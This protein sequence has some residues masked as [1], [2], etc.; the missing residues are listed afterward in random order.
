MGTTRG[1]IENRP[2][3]L[4]RALTKIDLYALL[5]IYHENDYFKIKLFRLAI[6]IEIMSFTARTGLTK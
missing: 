2:N 5:I 1:G 3:I 4:K 6:L